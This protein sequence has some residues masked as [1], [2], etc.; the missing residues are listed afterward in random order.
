MTHRRDNYIVGMKHLLSEYILSMYVHFYDREVGLQ[1]LTRSLLFC[2]YYKVCAKYL[3]GFKL[4][5]VKESSSLGGFYM[6]YN[7]NTLEVFLYFLLKKSIT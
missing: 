5:K 4:N 1:R 6:Q 7:R 2:W 3:S